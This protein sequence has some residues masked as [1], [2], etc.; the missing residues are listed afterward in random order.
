MYNNIQRIEPI[1]DIGGRSYKLSSLN[2][3]RTESQFYYHFSYPKNANKKLWNSSRKE[4]TGRPEH[5][6]FHKDGQTHLTLKD[7]QHIEIFN[8]A[9][10][11]FLPN[12]SSTIKPLLIHS[13]YPV[14]DGYYLPVV[15]MP[16]NDIRT[17]NRLTNNGSFSA[18]I[19]LVSDK[20]TPE[21]FLKHPLLTSPYGDLSLEMLGSIAGTIFAWEGW[22]VYYI[23]SSLSLHVPITA[24]RNTHS[25]FAYV[26]LHLHLRDLF[27]QMSF[28]R[29]N[30]H[31]I[32]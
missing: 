29:K 30:N 1:I 3:D 19:F 23:L 10:G 9:D 21:G 22:T 11:T 28:I 2:F 27:M 16:I 13:V 32:F 12:D 7:G 24:S 20:L 18:M 31:D 6:S 17:K 26:D 8:S 5:I 14:N 4:E 25:S 15:D